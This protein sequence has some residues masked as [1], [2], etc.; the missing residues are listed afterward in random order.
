M[1][2]VSQNGT[3]SFFDQIFKLDFGVTFTSVQMVVVYYDYFI[4]KAWHIASLH[5]L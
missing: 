3:P 2:R 4:T 1:K 5:F